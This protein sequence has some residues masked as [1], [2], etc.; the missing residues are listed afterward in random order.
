MDNMLAELPDVDEIDSSYATLVSSIREL[1]DGMTS[2]QQGQVST[3]SLSSLV[4]YEQ[5][6]A[7]LKAAEEE[8]A[9][10][11]E[12]AETTEEAAETAETTEA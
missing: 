3:S 12:T 2:Y 4:A 5:K 11:A 8:A 7:E 10:T 1:Y 6:I 9:Q